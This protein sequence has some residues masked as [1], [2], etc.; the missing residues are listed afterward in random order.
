MIFM[1]PLLCK[2]PCHTSLI[3]WETYIITYSIN[4]KKYE[5]DF[6]LLQQR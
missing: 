6:L 3:L 4:Q 2:S 5:E 1:Y